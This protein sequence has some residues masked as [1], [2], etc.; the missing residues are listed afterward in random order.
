MATVAAVCCGANTRSLISSMDKGV[1]KG[2]HA[3][4]SVTQISPKFSVLNRNFVTDCEE[5][6]KRRVKYPY[7]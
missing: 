6:G 7:S 3:C 5:N 2:L 1:I 4:Y